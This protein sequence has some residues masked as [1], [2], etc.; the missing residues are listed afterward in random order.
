MKTILRSKDLTCPS[1]VH[2]IEKVLKGLD[3]VQNARVH[4]TT[5]RIEVMHDPY[6]ASSDNLISAVRSTGYQATTRSF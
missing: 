1:C 5:G 2:K 3:G 6:L 4:F